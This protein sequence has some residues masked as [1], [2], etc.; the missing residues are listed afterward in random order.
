MSNRFSTNNFSMLCYSLMSLFMY[1]PGTLGCALYYKD[2]A[3]SKLINL[4]IF[5][6]NSEMLQKLLKF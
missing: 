5:F 2:S 6:S 3:R 4:E 1:M